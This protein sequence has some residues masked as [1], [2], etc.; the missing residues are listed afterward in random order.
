MLREPLISA[1]GFCF[2]ALLLGCQS[3]AP[4]AKSPAGVAGGTPPQAEPVSTTQSSAR[5]PVWPTSRPS[6]VGEADIRDMAE[7][8]ADA[9]S[10]LRWL[11]HD[12]DDGRLRQVVL[13]ANREIIAEEVNDFTTNR[14]RGPLGEGTKELVVFAHLRHPHSLSGIVTD[15]LPSLPDEAARQRALEGMRELDGLAH[16]AAELAAAALTDEHGGARRQALM[17]IP[18]LH[19]V[20]S[21]PMD[22]PV[23]PV[24]E[25]L[26]A[27]SPALR[28]RSAVALCVVAPESPA[29]ERAANVVAEQ[30]LKVREK[31]IS[32]MQDEGEDAFTASSLRMGLGYV[33]GG[34]YNLSAVAQRVLPELQGADDV[35]ARL[36]RARLLPQLGPQAVPA[37][38][39]LLS[40]PDPEVAEAAAESLGSLGASALKAVPAL[41]GAAHRT[42]GDKREGVGHLRTDARNAIGAIITDPAL[43]DAVP[44]EALV[45]AV[46]ASADAGYYGDE[47]SWLQQMVR[48]RQ[49][50]WAEAAEARLLELIH[51]RERGNELLER[52]HKLDHPIPS[53]LEGQNQE[54]REV[55]EVIE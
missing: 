8:G 4:E 35:A 26:D 31:A 10:R 14:L 44:I 50:E 27:D 51:A 52:L 17:A 11:Y 22:W 15:I 39:E 21:T 6:N 49:Q 48:E 47:T 36:L 54:E 24:E 29:G 46:E 30:L 41:A 1:V 37:L 40:D 43:T 53:G 5:H 9:L 34:Y 25:G 23:E 16:E 13:Q 55:I 12:L 38:T 28:L 20:M 18:D 42:S 2:I 19:V 32:K 3:S 7:Q 45:H 33:F